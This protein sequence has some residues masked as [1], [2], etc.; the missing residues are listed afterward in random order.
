MNDI[1]K[2]YNETFLKYYKINSKFN[3]ELI[4][5]NFC[6]YKYDGKNNKIKTKWINKIINLIDNK[7]DNEKDNEKDN[8]KD[9]EKDN[10][11]D[12]EKD[13]KKDN[14]KDNKKDNEKVQCQIN[15]MINSIDTKTDTNQIFNQPLNQTQKY[16]LSAFSN[17]KLSFHEFLELLKIYDLCYIDYYKFRNRNNKNGIF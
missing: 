17:I 12:N 15:K 7:K 5:N 1:I 3:I 2:N 10:K 9:N 16:L 4:D 6:F 14:E 13:N 8:K 11:K